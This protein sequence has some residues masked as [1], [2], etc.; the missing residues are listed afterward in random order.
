MCVE[1]V[2]VEFLYVNGVVVS[3]N[4]DFNMPR[5]SYLARKIQNGV[6]EG[7]SY[8]GKRTNGVG[9]IV[10]IIFYAVAGDPTTVDP[11]TKSC[12]VN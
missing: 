5:V 2:Y 9:K 1:D 8:D 6:H 10:Q 12:L 7:C 3:V 4:C 11:T